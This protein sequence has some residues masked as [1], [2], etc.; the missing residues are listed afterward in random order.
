MRKLTTTRL[1]TKSKSNAEAKEMTMNAS[2]SCEKV[3]IPV[4]IACMMLGTTF[5]GTWS[6]YSESGYTATA[7]G[8]TWCY[9]DCGGGVEICGYDNGDSDDWA[10]VSTFN[11]SSTKPSGSVMI[12]STLDGKSV[13]GIGDYAF[14]DCYNPTLTESD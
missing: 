13:V 1:T 10:W 11:C 14:Y 12:P 4:V 3:K 2:L 8:Y 5:A 7:N 9:R 6:G